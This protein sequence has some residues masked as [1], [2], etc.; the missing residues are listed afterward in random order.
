MLL[1]FLTN[2]NGC[3]QREFFEQEIRNKIL[4]IYMLRFECSMLET[5][6]F[7]YVSQLILLHSSKYTD[8]SERFN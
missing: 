1:T 6:V 4:E 3:V 2:I 7:S 8:I 5:S